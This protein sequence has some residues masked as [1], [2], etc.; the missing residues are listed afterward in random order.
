MTIEVGGGFVIVTDADIGTESLKLLL[1]QAPKPSEIRRLTVDPTS[2]TVFIDVFH[3]PLV[4]S[5]S[6]ELRAVGGIR[7]EGKKL[8]ALSRLWA[9]QGVICPNGR[10]MGKRV[11]SGNVAAVVI[12]AR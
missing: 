3:L 4:Q 8:A 7:V 11:D 12:A 9:L 1:C 2:G 6:R 5:Q 10:V